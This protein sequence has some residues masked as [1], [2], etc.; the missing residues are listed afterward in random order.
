MSQLEASL[1]EEPFNRKILPSMEGGS[2]VSNQI[3]DGFGKP[4]LV[5]GWGMLTWVE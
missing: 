5:E 4:H 3:K 2:T 1:N